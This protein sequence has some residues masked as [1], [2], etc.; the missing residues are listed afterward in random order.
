[1]GPGVKTRLPFLAVLMV[2]GAAPLPAQ[3]A[4]ATNAPPAS[5]KPLPFLAPPPMT[6][7]IPEAPEIGRL[8]SP[9][10]S[11]PAQATPPPPAPAPAAASAAV[12]NSAG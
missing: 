7:Q 2:S 8:P 12:E 4:P 1:M 5:V 11:V 6:S 9:T 10:N 3:N